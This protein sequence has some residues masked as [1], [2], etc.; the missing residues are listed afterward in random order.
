MGAR[1][2]SPPPNLPTLSLY[3]GLRQWTASVDHELLLNHERRSL[4][5]PFVSDGCVEELTARH[6]SITSLEQEAQLKV[7][8]SILPWRCIFSLLPPFCSFGILDFIYNLLLN[9]CDAPILLS[10][11][12]F[13]HVC[14][15]L[16]RH[17]L[18][19]KLPIATMA[20]PVADER[21]ID[22]S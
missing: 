12:P 3:I 19:V 2:P 10:H 17:Q 14:Q 9:V 20:M 11:V 4:S 15:G 22:S 21:S 18:L 7:S 8:H 6:P 1:P 13:P 5:L 16:Q